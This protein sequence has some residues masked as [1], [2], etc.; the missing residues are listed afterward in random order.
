MAQNQ[1]VDSRVHYDMDPRVFE[2]MLDRNMNY[3]S[4]YYLSGDEDLDVAQINKMKKIAAICGMKPGNRLLDIGCGWSGP[5]MYFAEHYGCDATG[6][7]VSE[8]QRDFAIEAAKRRGLEPRVHIDVCDVLD[9]SFAKE[10]FDQVIFLESIIHMREK[11]KI[12]ALCH[13]V[14]K[15]GGILFV[16]ESCYDRNSLTRKYRKDRGFQAV[17]QAFGYTGAMISGG[18]MLRLM[19]EAGLSP[20][21][22]ENVSNHYQ[23]TLSQWAENLDLHQ[24]ELREAAGDFFVE[25]RRYIMLAIATYRAGTTLCHLMAAQKSPN[26]W[27]GRISG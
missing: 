2:R 17:D 23:K 15:P 11:D 22:L 6:L 12:F 27:T 9:S 25:F 13:K 20:V 24:A 19:E 7:T 3:S 21:Y 18:E 8:V 16:Q 26:R 4:G 10:S 14:L 1:T 5:L